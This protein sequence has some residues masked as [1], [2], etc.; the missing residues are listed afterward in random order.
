MLFTFPKMAWTLLA[1]GMWFFTP[2]E[3]RAHL[4]LVATLVFLFAAL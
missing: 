4:G 1:A 2:E 3:S